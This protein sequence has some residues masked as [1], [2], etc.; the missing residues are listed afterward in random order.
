VH[1]LPP[2][3][4]RAQTSLI[5]RKGVLSPKVRALIEVLTEHSGQDDK[6][7][8]RRKNGRLDPALVNGHARA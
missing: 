7:R 6:P 8:A 5:W 1:S 4:A 3:L 2:A